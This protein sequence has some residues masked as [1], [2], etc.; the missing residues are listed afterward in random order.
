MSA[1]IHRL[2]GVLQIAGGFW[3][4]FE[5]TGRAF[6][7]REPLWFALLLLGALMF[8]LILIAGV[9]LIS[10]DAR[11]SAWSQWLQLAQVPILGTPWLS[12]G[13]HVGAVAALGFARGGHWSFGCRVPDI[14]WQ[15]YLGGSAHWFLGLNF[16]ALILFL[17]L[18]LTRR[19]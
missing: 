10:G 18:K 17:L 16:L 14:G 13:W 6:A 12:Y 11:G 2:I 1:M 3:G 15:L 19:A 5:L 7:V 4:L 8:L 9:W